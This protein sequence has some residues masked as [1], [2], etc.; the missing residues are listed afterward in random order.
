VK[1][2]KP[3]KVSDSPDVPV[4]RRRSQDGHL[5]AAMENVFRL[6]HGREMTPDERR[7]FGLA[8]EDDTTDGDRRRSS[9]NHHNR[10][11]L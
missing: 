6:T 4:V 10:D 7:V 2:Q 3:D 5:H 11:G 9:H 8:N 1:K